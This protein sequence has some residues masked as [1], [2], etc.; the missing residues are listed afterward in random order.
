MELGSGVY[1]PRLSD[2][3][4]VRGSNNPKTDCSSNAGVTKRLP[5]R[6]CN[7]D[8]LMR[9]YEGVVQLDQAGE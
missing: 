9:H 4:I 6:E 7:A 3:R 1:V 2:I 5:R 8:E